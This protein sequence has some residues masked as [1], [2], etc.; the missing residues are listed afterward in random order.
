[1]HQHCG[2]RQPGAM[3]LP[4][5]RPWH[6]QFVVSLQASS[7]LGWLF[8][9]PNVDSSICCPISFSSCCAA[10]RGIVLSSGAQSAFEL[11]GPPDVINLATLFGMNH[12][13]AK[14]GVQY[15]FQAHESELL[16]SSRFL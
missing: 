13:Q 1:M 12:H 15:A 9:M 8:H 7:D 3:C 5:R 4:M 16:C 6:G 2:R 14:V 10:G 11:R